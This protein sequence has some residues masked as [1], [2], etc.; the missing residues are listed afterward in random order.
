[1]T[2]HNAIIN[3]IFDVELDV[4]SELYNLRLP[5]LLMDSKGNFKFANRAALLITGYSDAELKAL[6]FNDLF[7]A[8]VPDPLSVL[9]NN[10]GLD[11]TMKIVHQELVE[12]PVHLKAYGVRVN[13]KRNFYYQIILKD[14][15]TVNEAHLTKHVDSLLD[16]LEKFNKELKGICQQIKIHSNY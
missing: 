15:Y 12:I 8:N 11:C 9:N 3:K 14:M 7:S 6:S 4:Y 1:M 5:F 2:Y 16:T 10:S 13:E